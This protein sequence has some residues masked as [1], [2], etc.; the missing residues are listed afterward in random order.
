VIT[1]GVGFMEGSA[2]VA[3]GRHFYSDVLVGAAAGTAIGTLIP[4]IHERNKRSKI[5]ITPRVTGDSAQLVFGTV[6]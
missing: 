4:Y 3:S 1:A 5:S 6:F 2:R